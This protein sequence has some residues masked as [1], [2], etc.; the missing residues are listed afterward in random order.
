MA[1]DPRWGRILEIP[2]EDPFVVGT[3]A[4]DYVRELQDVEGFENT[5]DLNSRRLKFS[6]CCKHYVACDVDNWLGIS[7]YSFHARVS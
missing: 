6:A 3:Y 4:A 5:T 7:H 1:R 2:G